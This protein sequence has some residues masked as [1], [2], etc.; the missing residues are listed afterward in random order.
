M[1]DNNNSVSISVLD[2]ESD[3][4]GRRRARAR[5]K[6]KK[7]V[8]RDENG[9][10]V[11]LLRRLLKHW[12]L[13]IIFPIVGFLVFEASIIGAKPSLMVNSQLGTPSKP[14]RFNSELSKVDKSTHTLEKD[15]KGNLNRLDPTTRVSGGVRQRKSRSIQ[16]FP[17]IFRMNEAFLSFIGP[18]DNVQRGVCTKLV[19]YTSHFQ[20]L[21]FS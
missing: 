2:D 9:F 15:P 8:H 1:F 4:L 6:R 17:L 10:A 21:D 7:L 14:V 19:D 18:K 16:F 20:L 13:L 5:R 3:E 12:M 11:R